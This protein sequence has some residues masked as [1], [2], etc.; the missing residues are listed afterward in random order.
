MILGVNASEIPRTLLEIT[1]KET[2][3]IY[4]ELLEN[5]STMTPVVLQQHSH[6]LCYV[7]CFKPVTNNPPRATLNR[8]P[9][10]IC[11]FKPRAHSI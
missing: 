1:V 3:E 10:K 9:E 4:G 8:V 5:R 7:F 11:V 2:P 6:L